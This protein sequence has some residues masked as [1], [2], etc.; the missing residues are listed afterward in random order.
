MERQLSLLLVGSTFN[1]INVADIK[2]LMIA[3][4]PRSEQDS[5]ASFL[6]TALLEA[7]EATR[8]AEREIALL[9]EYCTH[10]IADISP[11][12]ICHRDPGALRVQESH[13]P[14]T[15]TKEPEPHHEHT[16]ALQLR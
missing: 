13:D 6:D 4:P 16:F 8:I 1:R 9:N 14:H 5:I 12:Q 2:S 10:L 15:A 3:V 11:A 7:E